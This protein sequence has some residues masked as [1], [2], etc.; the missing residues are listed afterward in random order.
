MKRCYYTLERQLKLR[1]RAQTGHNYEAGFDYDLSKALNAD[2]S[3]VG[4]TAFTY[5][6]DN[7][8]HPTKNTAIANQSD[9]EFGEW[10][11]YSIIKKIS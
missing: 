1:I 4:F 7:Y 8:I 3:V 10:R 5:N 6:M 11:Q 2:S 9:I